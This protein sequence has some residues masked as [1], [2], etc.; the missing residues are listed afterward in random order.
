MVIPDDAVFPDTLA[1]FGCPEVSTL[2]MKRGC[3]VW[4]LENTGV[5]TERIIAILE[6]RLEQP[7]VPAKK[8]EANVLPVS[9]SAEEKRA[10]NGGLLR[11]LVRK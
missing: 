4:W 7:A 2:L 9:L 3:E 10:V 11:Y 5:L 6:K 1:R 8:H